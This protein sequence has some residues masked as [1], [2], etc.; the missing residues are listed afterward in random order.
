[1]TIQ[2]TGTVGEDD[3]TPEARDDLVNLYRRWKSK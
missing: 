3:L 2:A 1:M